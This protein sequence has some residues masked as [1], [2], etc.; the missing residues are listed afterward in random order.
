MKKV[1]IAIIGSGFGL[2]GLLPAFNSTKGCEV[3]AICGKKSARLVNY[4]KSIGLSKMYTD[5]K[6]LPDMEKLDAIAIAVT[7]NAQYKIA[8]VAINRGL[9]I[10]AEKPLAATY[11]QAKELLEL[12]K[13]KRVKH[14]VDFIFPEIEEWRKVKT[15]LNSKTYGRLKQI[16]TNWDFQSYFVRN[17]ENSWKGDS[18]KGGGAL[19]YYFSHTLY[20]LEH[21]GGRIS[22]LKSQLSYTKEIAKGETG[23]DLLLKF[24][25]GATGYAH[26]NCNTPGINRHHLEFILEKATIVLE[27]E[28]SYTSNFVVKLYAGNSPKKLL[29]VKTKKNSK[30]GEDERVRV[31]RNLTSRFVNSIIHNTESVPSF[32][33]G[34]RVQELIEKIRTKR[35]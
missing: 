29:S 13:K 19:S 10:F 27:N 26:L 7:P 4:C 12:A 24:V 20:Y 3:V 22:V 15:L 5:W 14:T 31:V 33:D 25:S 6:K 32:R 30:K 1:K 28:G 8:K 34:V 18:D 23:V 21:F 11:K 17:K 2:Y 9:H 16:N 35:L